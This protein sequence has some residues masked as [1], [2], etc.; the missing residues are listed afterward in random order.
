VLISPI[1]A[2]A[3]N[4]F[5]PSPVIITERILFISILFN[6]LS[7]SSKTWLFRAFKVLV[8][9]FLLLKSGL[10]LHILQILFGKKK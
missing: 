8:Y 7:N 9:L 3:T 2:P 6:I 5:C 4:D 1:S 10:L